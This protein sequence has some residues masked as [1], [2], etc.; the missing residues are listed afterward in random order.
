MVHKS[1]C[2]RLCSVAYFLVLVVSAVVSCS[3]GEDVHEP[4]HRHGTSGTLERV[5]ELE[6][7]GS[8]SL[9]DGYGVNADNQELQTNYGC[10]KYALA[11]M[12]SLLEDVLENV[13]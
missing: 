7:M 8:H 11:A 13:D 6:A 5:S 4:L 9:L 2:L 3:G 10:G 1:A 12:I